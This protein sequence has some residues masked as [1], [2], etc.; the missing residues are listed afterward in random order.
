MSQ[1]GGIVVWRPCLRIARGEETFIDV[2][3]C[4]VGHHQLRWAHGEV[5]MNIVLPDRRSAMDVDETGEMGGVP[6]MSCLA[7]RRL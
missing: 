6:C 7:I 2:F 1:S 3:V 5:G 4:C